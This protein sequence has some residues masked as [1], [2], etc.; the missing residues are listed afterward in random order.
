MKLL[1]SLGPYKHNWSNMQTARL[2]LLLTAI[3]VALTCVLLLSSHS[4]RKNY[5]L[6]GQV[7]HLSGSPISID[8]YVT[9]ERGFPESFEG[10]HRVKTEEKGKFKTEYNAEVNAPIHFYVR[11]KQEQRPVKYTLYPKAENKRLQ[12]LPEP[13]LYTTLHERLNP[14]HYYGDK[15]M[16]QLPTYRHECDQVER[17]F[18]PVDEIL[19]VANLS[20]LNCRQGIPPA[21]QG[22]IKTSEQLFEDALFREASRKRSQ[23]VS[24]RRK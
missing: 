15:G 7:R 14:E 17:S 19:Y 11:D 18:I 21:L 24:E 4:E 23:R 8:V 16:P 5:I 6:E 12:K 1:Y 22:D 13:I 20:I 2:S 3:L 9:Q 10:L